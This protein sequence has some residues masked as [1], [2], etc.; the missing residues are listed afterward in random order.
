MC[1][2]HVL[3]LPGRHLD[4]RLHLRLS[5][6]SP[7]MSDARA[8]AHDPRPR[9]R[10]ARRQRPLTARFKGYL[11]GFV[12]SVIL[13]AIP[14]WLVM[15]KVLSQPER[16]R[17]G[18]PGLRGRADRRAHGL[19]PAHEPEVGGRLDHAGADLHLRPGGHHPDRF[20]VGDGPPQP[21]HDADVARADAQHALTV[22]PKGGAE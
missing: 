21:Q 18:D 17:A 20:A 15:A 8:S 1:L 13:T 19:L 9:P 3:A 11:I 14:F 6:G 7:A 4:R 10:R 22:R 2:S 12:L 5:D 16:H